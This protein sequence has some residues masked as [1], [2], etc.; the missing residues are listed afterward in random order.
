MNVKMTLKLLF[1]NSIREKELESHLPPLGFGYLVSSLRNHLGNDSISC[2]VVNRDIEHA[3]KNFKPDIVGI[4]AVSQNYSLAIDYARLAKNT[5]IPVIIGGIHISALPE[6]ISEYMDVGVIGEGELSIVELVRWFQ[7]YGNFKNIDEIKGIVFR[8]DGRVF[9]TKSRDPIFPLDNIAMPARDIL[10][11]SPNWHMFTSRGCP[12]RCFFCAS[13]RFWN[14]TRFFSAEYVVN[15]IEYLVR[16]HNAKAIEFWDDLFIAD[17][18]RLERIVE[19]MGRRQLIGKVMFNCAVRSNT[20]NNESVRLMKEMGIKAVGM[21]LESGSSRTLHFLKGDNI[22]LS[23]HVN[24]L[25]S[26]RNN[27]IQTHVSF[28]IGSPG[29]KKNDILETLK[30]IKKNKV[31]SFDV[32]ALT[33]FPGTPAWEYAKNKGLVSEI[34]NWKTLG[35]D[36]EETH[37]DAVIVSDTMTREELYKLYNKFKLTKEKIAKRSSISLLAKLRYSVT[38]SWLVSYIW[39]KVKKR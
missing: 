32:Y 18:K 13:S 6:S 16:D 15:E 5:G 22:E 38:R 21:G 31:N 17:M 12:Y 36:F 28:I 26:L 1:I 10:P 8:K 27:G 29:E 2:I 14:K 25:N 11:A 30:F 20:V 34:M 24:A 3:M 7:K 35:M 33:P 9:L 39:L 19:L 4:T 37:N 23:D